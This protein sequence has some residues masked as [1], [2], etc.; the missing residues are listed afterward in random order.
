MQW[1][2]LAF[3]SRGSTP[4][5]EALRDAEEM[6]RRGLAAGFDSHESLIEYAADMLSESHEGGD[7]KGVATAALARVLEERKQ[8]MRSWPAVTDCDRLDAAFE[9]LNAM[10][11]MARHN[12]TC[13]GTC[14]AAEMPLEMDRLHGQWEGVPIV[15]NVYYHAQDSE[16]AADGEHLWLGYGSMKE[17]DS[18]EEYQANSV[19]I[20]EMAVQVLESHGLK[21]SWDGHISKRLCVELK[22][23]RRTR[24]ARFCG[25]DEDAAS[26][27]N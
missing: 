8:E 9:E 3:W 23:Q 11:I 18:D 15:G 4:N 16:G 26:P 12:W 10:G 2:N 25:G 20:A 17:C 24:P 7:F 22:W 5:P 13:C 6:I 27:L 14:A 1:R 21:V 19:K